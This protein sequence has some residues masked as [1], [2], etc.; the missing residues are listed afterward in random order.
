FTF[1]FGITSQPKTNIVASFLSHDG[2]TGPSRTAQSSSRFCTTSL[3]SNIV[4]EVE[5]MSFHLHKS[6]SRWHPDDPLLI[7]VTEGDDGASGCGCYAVD[8]ALAF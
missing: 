1:F 3:R 7:L 8:P 2:I 4:V 5:D 6:K